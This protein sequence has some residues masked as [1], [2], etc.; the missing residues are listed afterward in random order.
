MKLST[1][2][3]Q[4][5]EFYIAVNALIKW[6]KRDGHL[7]D[8]QKLDTLMRTAWT[9]SSELL[10][11]M[12]LVLQSMKGNYSQELRKEINECFKFALHHRKILG[13]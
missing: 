9:T 5:D 13:L 7:E 12:A 2:F 1:R 8:S 6:L 10:G 4:L 11:E 3:T